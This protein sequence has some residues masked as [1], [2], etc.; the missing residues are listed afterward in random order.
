[1]R[2]QRFTR[3]RPAF[4]RQR[5]NGH[6]AGYAADQTIVAGTTYEFIL[7][8]NTF[9]AGLAAGGKL[10]PRRVVINMAFQLAGLPSSSSQ[11]SYYVARFMT[12]LTTVSPSDYVWDPTSNDSDLYEKRLL[13]IGQWRGVQ[14]ASVATGANYVVENRTLDLTPRGA[15]FDASQEELAFVIGNGAGSGDVQARFQ[16]R[17]YCSWR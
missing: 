5:M 4:R 8:D 10:R 2:T 3:S 13:H 11:L 16:F 7:W 15:S 1:M 6:W 14:P 12:D 9:S 17:T